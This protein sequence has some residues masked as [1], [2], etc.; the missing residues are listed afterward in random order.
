MKNEIIIVFA[1]ILLVLSLSYIIFSIQGNL[2]GDK[3]ITSFAISNNPTNATD[4][5][6]EKNITT[7]TTELTALN[8][9]N[10]SE[11]IIK[12]M[13]ENNFSVV[14]M[15]D[16]LA[17]AKR[18]FQQAEYA[19][20]LRGAGN[21]SQE[22]RAKAI[23]ALKLINWKNL[24]YSSVL[25]YTDN[26]KSRKEQ[27][28][29]IYDSVNALNASIEKYKAQGI[30]INNSETLLKEANIAFYEDRYD[31]CQNILTELTNLIETER[32]SAILSL[33]LNGSN[34]IKKYWLYSLLSLIALCLI[35][36]FSYKKIHRANLAKKINKLNVEE[37][38]LSDLI[39][40][41]QIERFKENKISSLVYSIRI[42]EYQEKLNAIKEELPVLK[43]KLK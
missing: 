30:E 22:D 9:I 25:V 6:N 40:R 26:I 24:N 34:F 36:F 4:E 35:C 21:F 16:M 18:I 43:A 14:Y 7:A 2:Q 41:T 15:N 8:A 38:V 32:S 28:F 1:S 29:S 31:D 12:I 42:K 11:D 37:K 3:I 33:T 13:Q 10:E 39:K 27:A 17:E 23:D 19:D 20:M 5:Q